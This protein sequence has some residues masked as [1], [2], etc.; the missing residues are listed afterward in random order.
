MNKSYYFGASIFGLNFRFEVNDPAIEGLFFLAFP[1]ARK[2]SV[3]DECEQ[4]AFAVCI[5]IQESEISY[6][7]EVFRYQFS[8]DT[9]VAEN[10]YGAVVVGLQTN[11]AEAHISRLMLDDTDYFISQVLHFIGFLFLCWNQR[12]PV[13]AAAVNREGNTLLLI[14]QSGVGKS[15]LTYA[16][17][18]QGWNILSE[19]TTFL[20]LADGMQIWGNPLAIHLLPESQELF[21]ELANTPVV[22]LPN[23]KSKR[24]IPL[25]QQKDFASKKISLCFLEAKRESTDSVVET[26]KSHQVIQYLQN[27]TDSGFDLP[28]PGKADV[29]DSLGKLSAFRVSIGSDIDLAVQTLSELVEYPSK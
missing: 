22:D 6:T 26:V 25:V 20:H 1:S 28:F 14:G 11:C 15:S 2:L 3:V 19:D 8:G 12:I 27:N 7:R 13:H 24:R 5:N 16:C 18:K 23:G 17:W 4:P 21:P 9:Y 29:M 10:R